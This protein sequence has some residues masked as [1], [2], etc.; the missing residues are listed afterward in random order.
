MNTSNLLWDEQYIVQTVDKKLALTTHRLIKRRLPFTKALEKS[1]MLEDII[2]WEVK[3]ANNNLYSFLSL[4]T[5]LLTF[6]NPAFFLLSG[7]FLLLFL[8]TRKPCVHIQTIN[9]VMVL[10]IEVEEQRANNLLEMV[11]Q[12]RQSRKALF[13]NTA[14]LVA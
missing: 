5:A 14:T 1:V 4:G 9:S 13:A 8:L 2:S 3:K 10:P 7:F 12:A 11:K 6:A